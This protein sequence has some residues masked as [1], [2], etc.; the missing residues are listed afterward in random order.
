MRFAAKFVVFVML[1]TF[2]P[3]SL[4]NAAPIVWCVA[5]DDHSGLELS[6]DGLQ[7]TAVTQTNETG[8]RQSDHHEAPCVDYDLI[9]VAITAAAVDS[10]SPALAAADSHHTPARFQRYPAPHLMA[11]RIQ[12]P[13]MAN[14]VSARLRHIRTTILRL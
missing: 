11:L 1:A 14:A 4:L 8:A 5:G 3:A 2:L 7:Q 13:P 12:P 6:H 9:G 10:E